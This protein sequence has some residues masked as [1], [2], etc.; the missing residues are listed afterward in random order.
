MEL[1]ESRH[2]LRLLEGELKNALGA[3]FVTLVN[4]GSSANLAAAIWVKQRCGVRRR[5]LLAGFSFPTT[6]ASFTLLGFDVR[7][8]DTEPDGFNLDPEALH[9]EL[10]DQV[11][12][13]VVTHFLGF[14]AQLSR[15]AK[16]ARAHGALLVQDACETMNLLVDG[17]RLHEH[18]DVVTH[19]FYHPHHLSSFG[20]GA[21]VAPSPE[22]HDHLQSIVHW[23]RSCRCHYDAT[24]C[25]APP[26]LNHNFWYQR[27][28][29]NVEM[30]E[31]NACFARWQ[32][33]SWPEQEARRW[34]HWRLW[35]KAM[36]GIPGVQTWPA[37]GNVSPFVFPIGV[38][39]GRFAR[40]AGEIMARGVEVR[41]L[42]GGAIHLH[43]A[44]KHLAHAGLKQCA[45]MGA[46]SFFVGM[47]QTLETE[48]V[49]RATAIV[50][51]ALEKP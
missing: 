47:H 49:E 45:A 46:R 23:G 48:K 19:S 4:S 1:G 44:Y 7:L 36:A 25:E 14:P 20:G 35:E 50:R 40:V 26:G 34:Q 43:P 11:A 6:I 32:L 18:G 9:Q 8:V 15:I 21:V 29:V 22:V 42:M 41:S 30:S 24:R 39:P 13:V 16:A 3:P 10:N 27:E 38:S 33:V 28:G 37:G 2:N 5:V 12:A 51:E 17:A 31:L